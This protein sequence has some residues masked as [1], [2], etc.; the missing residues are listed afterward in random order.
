MAPR[1]K[2][3][4][5]RGDLRSDG[6]LKRRPAIVPLEPDSI[7]AGAAFCLGDGHSGGMLA[8][9]KDTTRKL[10]RDAYEAFR[11]FLADVNVDPC[12]DGWEQLP[13]NSLA[14]FYRWGLDHRCGGLTDRTASSYA[15]AISALL[16]QLLIEERL[17]RTISLEKLRIGLRESLARGDYERRKVDPRIDAFVARV[18]A[19]PVRQA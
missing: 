5:L 17:P 12:V 16:R 9:R 8:G 19:R 1:Q 6:R 11:R 15:Y 14:A 3:P 7:D 10:Y 2:T 18:A 4:Q 13:P